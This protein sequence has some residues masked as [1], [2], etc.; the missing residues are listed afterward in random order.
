MASTFSF[1][2]SYHGTFLSSF[3]FSVL[4]SENKVVDE[5]FSLVLVDEINTITHNARK[6]RRAKSDLASVR[7]FIVGERQKRPP[8]A[9]SK[10]NV[11]QCIR[12][13]DI[14]NCTN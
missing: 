10:Q 9:C 1:S 8:T 5:Y 13:T 12:A 6:P 7:G 11:V 4:V 3:F 2:L 14:R